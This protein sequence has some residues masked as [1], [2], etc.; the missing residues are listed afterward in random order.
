MSRRD[1]RI[2]KSVKKRAHHLDTGLNICGFRVGW[3]FFFG[4]PRSMIVSFNPAH[5]FVSRYH[6]RSRRRTQRVSGL[7]L[8]RAK[9]QTSRVERQSI[10]PATVPE[11]II[12]TNF[13]STLMFPFSLPPWL[14]NR[15]L[16][17]QAIATVIGFV[18]LVGDVGIAIFKTNSRNAA[19]LEEYLR[20]RGEEF[21]KVQ[22]DRVEDPKVVKPGAGVEGGEKIPG[23]APSQSRFSFFS[24]S[25][26]QVP[27]VQ[28][29]FTESKDKIGSKGKGKGK[30]KNQ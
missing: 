24:R 18:P 2:L 19:L 28:G 15:M 29:T 20:V 25:S 14:S 17:N 1:A 13:G 4:A 10:V 30:E 3:T 6:P 16:G 23:K 12:I 22:I 26:K 9:G 21:L 27:T 11:L 5:N 7:L 8:G